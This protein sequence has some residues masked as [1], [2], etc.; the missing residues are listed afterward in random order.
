MAKLHIRRKSNGEMVIAK[1]EGVAPDRREVKISIPAY[2]AIFTFTMGDNFAV[3]TNR[4]DINPRKK[5]IKHVSRTVY[6]KMAQWAWAILT[7]PREVKI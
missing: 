5:S 2:N 7:D 4:Q 3:L 6:Q 1:L